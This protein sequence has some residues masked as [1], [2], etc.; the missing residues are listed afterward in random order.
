MSVRAC[1]EMERDVRR[2]S[3]KDYPNAVSVLFRVFIEL[4]ADEYI[5]A[6][7]L[8]TAGNPTL[9]NKLQAVTQDLVTRKKLTPQQAKPVRRALQKDYFLAA[10]TSLMNAYVHNQYVFPS[11]SDLRSG[12][13]SLQPFVIAMLAS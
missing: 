6:A 10:S 7:A 11:P 13:N 4:S 1:S 8:P 2:L 12:L 5:D 9:T 3:L